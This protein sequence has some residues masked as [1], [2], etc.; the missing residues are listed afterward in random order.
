MK[1]ALLKITEMVLYAPC[2]ENSL[3]RHSLA[4]HS[5]SIVDD[6]IGALPFVLEGSEPVFL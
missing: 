5:I 2:V 4:I 3:F 1:F 6:A